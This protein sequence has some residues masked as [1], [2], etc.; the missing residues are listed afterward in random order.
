[1]SLPQSWATPLT[2]TPLPIGEAYVN[3]ANTVRSLVHIHPSLQETLSQPLDSALL[4]GTFR[5]ISTYKLV[6]IV[7]FLIFNPAHRPA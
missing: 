6:D 2:P 3:P 4:G 5:A 7:G 1:M